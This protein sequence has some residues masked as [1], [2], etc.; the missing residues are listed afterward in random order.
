MYS[1]TNKH[2]FFVSYTV[3]RACRTKAQSKEEIYLITVP[4]ASRAFT[5][6]RT[7]QHIPLLPVYKSASSTSVSNSGAELNPET[8]LSRMWFDSCIQCKVQ[9]TV[10]YN[11]LKPQGHEMIH[12]CTVYCRKVV[13]AVNDERKM[14]RTNLSGLLVRYHLGIC[15]KWL[16]ISIIYARVHSLSKNLA[17]NSNCSCPNG[18]I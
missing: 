3:Q 10:Q 16:R 15:L 7:E 13:W 9:C 8:S 2:S 17:A 18:E 1:L 11:V 14:T 4:S 12:L 6:S 5:A